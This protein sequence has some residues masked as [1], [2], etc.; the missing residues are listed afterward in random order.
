[1]GGAEL[2]GLRQHAIRV[3]AP[4][5]LVHE[6]EMAP[7]DVAR[8]VERYLREVRRACERNHEGEQGMRLRL[9]ANWCS[10]N[11]QLQAKSAEMHLQLQNAASAFER[12]AQVPS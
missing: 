5:E 7:A 12:A 1:M 2:G 4:V 8:T 10:Q 6:E 3:R 9:R 11:P